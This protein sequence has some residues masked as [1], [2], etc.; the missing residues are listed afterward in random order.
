MSK[1]KTPEWPTPVAVA[2][3]PRDEKAMV[4]LSH[5]SPDQKRQAFSRMKSSDPGTAK[6]LQQMGRTFGPSTTYIDEDTAK[7]LE[8]ANGR[9]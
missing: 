6:F 9:D 2:K 1:Q 7:R 8:V 4:C 5:L 3:G